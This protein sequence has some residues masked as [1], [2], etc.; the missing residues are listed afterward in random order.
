M[1]ITGKRIRPPHPR[2]AHGVSL[3][4]SHLSSCFSSTMWEIAIKEQS[5]VITC[6]KSLSFL[7]VSP[8]PQYPR[9]HV[10]VV[11][12]QLSADLFPKLAPFLCSFITGQ[13]PPCRN[14]RPKVSLG[15][16]YIS[17][18]GQAYETKTRPPAGYLR[19]RDICVFFFRV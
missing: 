12:S 2:V 13:Q 17:F 16:N 8:R 7:F 15:S 11:A 1:S 19:G 5:S 14:Y 6:S 4:D 10:F 18:H 3:T 9:G